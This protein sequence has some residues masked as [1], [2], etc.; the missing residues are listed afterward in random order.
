MALTGLS[1]APVDAREERLPK[2]DIGASTLPRALAELS[3]EAHISIGA[4]GGLPHRPT[5][6]VRGRLS[7]GDALSRLLAGSGYV[8]RQVGATAWRV[9]RAPPQPVARPVAAPPPPRPLVPIIITGS[10]REEPLYALPLSVSVVSLPQRNAFATE[11]GSADIAS[12]I[13][14]LSLTGLGPGRNRMFLRGI[15]DSAFNG[16][17]QATVAVVLD[18][19]R[20][21]Y[22]APDPD[23]R[24]VDMERVEVLKGPQGS[25]YGSG[26]LGGI[27][28]MVSRKADPD[29]FSAT[30]SAGAE[31]VG[32]GGAG[33]MVSAVA[34]LPLARDHV[35]LRLVGYSATEPGWIDTGPREASN[36]MR[37]AGG[38][39]ALG[40]RLGAD[41]RADVTGF[42]QWLESRDS[43][44][45][46]TSG[47]RSRPAQLA[48][49]H[50]NDLRHLSMRLARDTGPL[51]ITA[52][53]GMTWHDV[54]DVLDAT[55][56]AES[57]GLADPRIVREDRSYRLWDNEARMN[58]RVGGIGWLAGVSHVWTRQNVVTDLRSDSAALRVDDDRRTVTELA[59]FG[60]VA[61]PLTHRLTLDV[62]G[63]LFRSV[64]TEARLT[65]GG[66]QRFEFRRTGVT[67]GFALSWRPDMDEIVFLRY[68]SAIRQGGSDI[69]STGALERLRGDELAM[70]EAG[71]RRELSGGGRLELGAWYGWWDN[72][73]SDVLQ[74]N[75]L[76]E[77]ENAGNARTLGT[78]A[79]LSLPVAPGWKVDLG[80]NVTL[81]RLTRNA[82]GYELRDRDLPVV[83]RYTLRGAI[84]HNFT[85]GRA[86][87]ALRVD[88]R[89]VG[90][91][92]LSFDP[93][94]DRPMGEV[95]EAGAEGR[96]GLNGFT[97]SVRADNILGGKG[98]VFA[99]GNSLR[100][101]TMRQYT[102]QR[103]FRFSIGLTRAF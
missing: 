24:L 80:G 45:V 6:L 75:G 78:E 53:S 65:T 86:D 27:Y 91:S 67:P 96:F 33:H 30:V 76:I 69:S 2:I 42:A 44:Y 48:E 12:M 29:R 58:G 61:V 62:G 56:G 66:R 72:V 18:E 95:F 94:L 39:A 77:T 32:G 41:W 60:N 51:R 7:I 99:F 89:Y 92:R 85:L 35:G 70:V 38:R 71:W 54:N 101:A 22:S 55:T 5:P 64:V 20:L 98:D 100:F 97:L 4:E 25:L 10:K 34:N 8:A 31:L 16:E 88:L 52:S 9:E 82:L 21:T 103:P 15:A 26:A 13:E 47:A 87:A 83:P 28:H 93:A 1:P 40:I 90:P 50:D 3:R 74:S 63:R 49:P 68:G 81:A 36:E 14:G 73:Q 84:G 23:I 19:A 43:S 57:F 17:S 37:V 102:P 46:Y 79:A 11:Q 59:A